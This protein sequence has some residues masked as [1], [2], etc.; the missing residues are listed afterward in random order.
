MTKE[1]ALFIMEGNTVDM[2]RDSSDKIGE[3]C[4]NV[5]MIFIMRFL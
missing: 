5:V 2:D 3:A 4:G 1:T